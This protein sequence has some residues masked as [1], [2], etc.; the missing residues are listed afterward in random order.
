MVRLLTPLAFL[1]VGAA[2]AW[3]GLSGDSAETVALRQEVAELQED[4]AQREFQLDML[5]ARSRVA[6]LEV[7]EQYPD[8]SSRSGL[9]TR[10]HFVEID[11]EGR[12]LGKGQEFTIDGALVYLDAQVI[13]FDDHFVESQDLLR[14]SSLLL[15]RRIFGEYQNPADGFVID[16][17]G[18][19]PLA[20]APESG[21]N[22]F[23]DELWA[24]FWEYAN[25]PAVS[26]QSGVRAMHG[27]APYIKLVENKRYSV[28]LRHAGGLSISVLN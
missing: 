26:R 14:G 1:L 3:W 22:A 10:F 20:Y 18:E 21:A 4:L 11:R 19:R 6:Q 16:T 23:Q 2:A 5:R 25:D 15:F 7:L 24:N 28:E 17:V 9:R 12:S 27:E 13:K 8:P